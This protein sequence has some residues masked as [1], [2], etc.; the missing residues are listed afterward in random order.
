MHIKFEYFHGTMENLFQWCGNHV[1]TLND[2]EL[3]GVIYEEYMFYSTDL[4]EDNRLAFLQAGYIN[5]EIAQ[6]MKIIY[7]MSAELFDEKVEFS[8][9]FVRNSPAWKQVFDLMDEI[10]K[11][12]NLQ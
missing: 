8:A 7:D 10:K 2:E 9:K 5:N 4:H 6:K 3:E 11:E 12:I 1:L